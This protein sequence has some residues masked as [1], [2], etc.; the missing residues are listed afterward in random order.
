MGPLLSL[1]MAAQ[2]TTLAVAT[3]VLPPVFLVSIGGGSEAW[4]SWAVF[5]GAGVSGMATVVQS[6]R[7]GR[8]GARGTARA[9]AAL[10]CC[11]ERF[12]NDSA[13]NAY[14]WLDVS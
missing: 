9:P 1:G 11:R 8:I 5:A 4:L 14:G 12:S 13:N 3:V 7:V 6:Q 2:S 10:G